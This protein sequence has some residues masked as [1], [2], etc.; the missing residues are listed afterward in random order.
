MD[1]ESR[2]LAPADSEQ[3]SVLNSSSQDIESFRPQYGLI[4]HNL[5]WGVWARA[6]CPAASP[7][8]PCV[9][10]GD[11]RSPIVCCACGVMSYRAS[12]MCGV[13]GDGGRRRPGENTLS[14][15]STPR[16]HASSGAASA[17]VG[18]R[19]LPVEPLDVIEL[20]RDQGEEEK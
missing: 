10:A 20:L 17:T 19:R 16:G 13:R 6:L 15:R 5:T 18:V 1:F 12:R 7:E 2:E 3:Q 14:V 9:I 11:P 4:K 8:C